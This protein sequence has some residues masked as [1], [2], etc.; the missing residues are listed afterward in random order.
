[1]SD[2]ITTW[3]QSPFAATATATVAAAAAPA[4]ATITTTATTTIPMMNESAVHA[5]PE[6]VGAPRRLLRS[7]QGE[8][9]DV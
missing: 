8:P 3:K 9:N 7:A 5:S 6:A 4:T 2:V 1:M